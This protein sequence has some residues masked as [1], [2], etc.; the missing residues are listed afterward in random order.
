MCTIQRILFL[1]RI[2]KAI[3]ALV[4]LI[5]RAY[6]PRSNELQ[7]ELTQMGKARSLGQTLSF[8]QI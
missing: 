5:Q 7:F 2:N 3:I 1:Y 4:I 8:I 6:R